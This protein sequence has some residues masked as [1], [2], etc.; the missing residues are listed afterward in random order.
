MSGWWLVGVALASEPTVTQLDDSWI[1]A[2]VEVLASA[3]RV[4]AVISDPAAVAAIEQ[5]LAGFRLTRTQKSRAAAAA[6]EELLAIVRREL[7]HKN[8]TIPRRHRLRGEW[9]YSQV[10][11]PAI[12]ASVSDGESKVTRY[13]KVL[14][15]CL[16]HPQLLLSRQLYRRTTDVIGIPSR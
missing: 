2:S 1:E 16:K 5:T 10:L 3:E 6:A 11:L 8:A 14:A 9:I 13:L 4:S 7:W 12:A 15:L